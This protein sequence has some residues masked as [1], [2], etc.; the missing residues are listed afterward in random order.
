MVGFYLN[1]QG[2]V[3]LHCSKESTYNVIMLTCAHM[4]QIHIFQVPVICAWWA[5][6]KGLFI[7]RVEKLCR[8]RWVSS[9]FFCMFYLNRWIITIRNFCSFYTS[10]NSSWMTHS[11]LVFFRVCELCGRFVYISPILCLENGA[12]NIAFIT[13]TLF[14]FFYFLFSAHGKGSEAIY[15]LCY[16]YLTF[17]VYYFCSLIRCKRRVLRKSCKTRWKVQVLTFLTVNFSCKFD[18]YSTIQNSLKIKKNPTIR[19]YPLKIFNPY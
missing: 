5:I 2:V 3:Q 6:S 7:I 13:Y 18:Q 10:L 12:F 1:K 15:L 17:M 9:E 19:Y 16:G 8:F 14:A 4:A 11:S